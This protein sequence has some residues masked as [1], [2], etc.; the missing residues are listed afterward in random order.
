MYEGSNKI[1]I[2]NTIR[3][4]LVIDT[5]DITFW[6][7]RFCKIFVNLNVNNLRTRRDREKRLHMEIRP[8]RSGEGG[9][10][11]HY[12]KNIKTREC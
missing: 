3:F 6:K 8:T 2:Y 10:Y 4:Q 5:Y 1:L 11:L 9:A 12:F 7:Y